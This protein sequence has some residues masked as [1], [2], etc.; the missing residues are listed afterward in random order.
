MP[1]PDSLIGQT[2]SHFRIVEKLGGGGMGVVYKAED[3][4]L[5]R[6]VALKF[7]PDEVAKDP[8]ALSRFE[9]E[10]KAASALNHPNICTIYEIDD[11]AGEPFIAMEF[12]D[13]TTLKH[14][15]NG[16]PLELDL[17]LEL[18]IEIA[19]ALDAA[20]SKGI[21]HRDIKPANL[22]VTA[23]G[24]AKVLDFGLAKQL[25]SASEATQVRDETASTEGARS[26]SEADLTSPGTTV[27]T[28]AYMSPEQIRGRVLDA[29]TDL[30]S[31]GIVMYEAA[32]GV[33]PF[34]GE[35]SGIITDAILNRTPPPLV[36]MNPN[37]PPKLEDILGKALEKDP[38]L[39]YQHASEMRAD[40]QRLKRDSSA[41]GRPVYNEDEEE[42]EAE[43]SASG[44][45][46]RATSGSS[47]SAA[48]P[49]S[50][51][52]SSTR[53]EA[54]TTPEI[55]ETPASPLATNRPM[56]KWIAGGAVLAALLA[57]GGYFYLHQTPKLSEKDVVVLGDFLNTTGDA[58]FDGTLRQ[59]LA[60]QLEQSPF[61]TLIDE[62]HVQQTLKM[63]QQPA[64]ARL[65]AALAREV[66]QRTNSMA[67]I[68]SSIAQVGSEY[69]LIAKA[70]NC[71]SGE[72]LASAQ[73]TAPDKNHVLDALSKV[74]TDLRAKLGESLSTVKK[75]DT[76]V[77]QASTSSLEALQAYSQART[78]TG[79]SDFASSIPLLQKAIQLDPN[80]AMAYA[81]IATAYGDIGELSLAAQNAS[82][83]YELRDRVSE[84]ERFYIDAHYDQYAAGDLAKAREVYEAWEKAYP[85]D[86][87]PYTNLGAIDSELGDYSQGLA[88][89]E[90][91][92][93]MNPSG[94]NYTNLIG[95]YITL[96]RFDEAA[97][98]A[99]DA[100][101]KKLDT[102]FLRTTLY[103][104]AF[105]KNDPK[106]MAEQ[107]AWSRGKEGVEDNL[108]EL[109]ADTLA[110]Y[111]Q[112][113]NAATLTKQAADLAVHAGEKETAAS[114][115][116]QATIRAGMF[117]YPEDA[118]RNAAA[119]L[120][121]GSG[122]DLGYLT[123]LGLA[124]AGDTAKAEAMADSLAKLSSTDTA[125]NSNYL[126]TIRA[127]I[128]LNKH[129]PQKALDEL[130]SAQKYELGQSAIGNV[131]PGLYIPYI[132]G[133]AYL[134]LKQGKEAAAEFQKIID[135]SGVVINNPNAIMAYL[136]LA[137]AYAVAGDDAKARVAYQN[138]FAKWKD[139][140]P[141]LPVLL[142]AKAE[143]AK[144]K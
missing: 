74:A 45:V 68:D 126:P 82:K 124:F 138:L 134:A 66:C 142:Q 115:W 143:Y 107:V 39:R 89:A 113:R 25:A 117:G 29:R 111:G 65:T 96:N 33:L 62:D 61:L 16:S 24:H 47:K 71:N 131:T 52:R 20:H 102:G 98:L 76:P 92:F 8:Q 51:K 122:R 44:A 58:V 6:F 130:A 85:R 11:Q 67:T 116:G 136:G 7:L 54:A 105:I 4:K 43:V 133:E 101:A 23:R 37:V 93:K 86:N 84:R 60:V 1:S 57:A 129:D 97:S 46:P 9:R 128:A 27:G 5:S 121:L 53:T 99:A 137:R 21:I 59:G 114:Y 50:G 81:A 13:G 83:A 70:V 135:R 42:R 140:D 139:A 3:V 88:D 118:R 10:A 72:T 110:Y 95:N 31:F 144:L 73:A 30:F 79:N 64:D 108:V 77:E 28:V 34:R 2:I 14:R 22:F 75:F 69:T 109:E 36:R 120:A 123:A 19:D 100:Q 40:L 103:M 90:M 55:P 119:S 35:T 141:D 18:A 125:L 15:I 104:L 78:L 63:M 106:V 80:F 38:K 17:L 112:Y 49:G 41:S 94:L 26:V 56:G 32:T 87:I 12:L 132:R 48:K 127:Q 91:A